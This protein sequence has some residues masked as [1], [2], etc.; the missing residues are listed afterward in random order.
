M[1]YLLLLSLA[2]IISSCSN[3]SS[4]TETNIKTIELEFTPQ[5]LHTSNPSYTLM[6]SKISNIDKV[7]VHKGDKFCDSFSKISE[8]TDA[9]T[10]NGVLISLSENKSEQYYIGVYRNSLKLDCILYGTITHDDLPPADLAFSTSLTSDIFNTKVKYYHPVLTG[11]QDLSIQNIE[12]YTDPFGANLLTRYRYEDWQSNLG[13]IELTENTQNLIYFSASDKANN[14]STIFGPITI[15][16]DDIAP[17]Q[18]VLDPALLALNGG[19]VVNTNITLQGTV[20]SDTTQINVY[21]DHFGSSLLFSITSAQFVSGYTTSLTVDSLNEFFIKSADSFG[22]ESESVPLSL[23]QVGSPIYQYSLASTSFGD[24]GDMKKNIKEFKILSLFNNST[25]G[26]TSQPIKVST[27]SLLGATAGVTVNISSCLEINPNSSCFISLELNYSST[28]VKAITVNLDLDGTSVNLDFSVN[29]IDPIA[30]IF[31]TEL[32]S[33]TNIEKIDK[34]SK[35]VL[36]DNGIIDIA[37][38]SFKVLA[39]PHVNIVKNS[40]SNMYPGYFIAPSG[41]NMDILNMDANSA[42]TVDL[43][44]NTLIE[45]DGISHEEIIYT[46]VVLS[47]GEKRIYTTTISTGLSSFATY[48]NVTNPFYYNGDPHI[49]HTQNKLM[50]LKSSNET[51]LAQNVTSEIVQ[52]INSGYFA[53]MQNGSTGQDAVYKID[54]LGNSTYKFNADSIVS[55]KGREEV[56]FETII[57]GN[58]ELKISRPTGL[59]DIFV[60][61]DLTYESSFECQT[62]CTVNI[63]VNNSNY[64]KV[65]SDETGFTSSEIIRTDNSLAYFILGK[66]FYYSI[67][68]GS[69]YQTFDESDDSLVNSQALSVLTDLSRGESSSVATKSNGDIMLLGYS[70]TAITLSQV[71]NLKPSKII[72]VVALGDI[73]Y[74]FYVNSSDLVQ[75]FKVEL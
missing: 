53:L 27:V 65:Y 63:N 30:P 67:K 48:L 37:L 31:I 41:T 1:K 9:Q 4:D 44:P 35:Y 49:I 26:V 70:E 59:Q 21:S 47:N 11:V 5:A 46:K 13:F 50:N 7:S 16:H 3:S 56:L 72:N 22:N 69:L 68:S 40:I 36:L 32:A 52:S 12:F 57:G 61:S 20:D 29:V 74:L 66:D 71:L 54:L 28:G 55:V 33:S 24:I 23:I 43:S 39:I 19:I 2:V 45:A 64:T 14:S 38:E 18:V 25:E 17:A 6:A 73:H 62:D 75:M 42:Y 15:N 58:K 34:E 8:H 10:K 60:N 51:T